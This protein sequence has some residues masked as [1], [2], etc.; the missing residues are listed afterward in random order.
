MEDLGERD[1]WSYREDAWE[2]RRPYYQSALEEVWRLHDRGW[3]GLARFPFTL[4][5]EFNAALYRWE[6]KYFF[7]NCLGRYFEG[8]HRPGLGG[9]SRGVAG[10]GPHRGESWPGGLACS[11]TGTSSHRTFSSTRNTP[12]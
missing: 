8:L 11:C 2:V 4:Q 3:Q 7:E 6:Q 10:L 1:L 9:W 12:T 5:I